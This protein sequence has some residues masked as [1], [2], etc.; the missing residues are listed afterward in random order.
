MQGRISFVS[1][2]TQ[3][4]LNGAGFP[5]SVQHDVT[6]PE[7]VPKAEGETKKSVK[8]RTVTVKKTYRTRI[9]TE[10]PIQRQNPLIA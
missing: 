3:S 7:K 2:G 4:D 5:G 9:L 10:I 8:L 6:K 1:I